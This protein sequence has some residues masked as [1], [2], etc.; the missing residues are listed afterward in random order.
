MENSI[1][2]MENYILIME[3]QKIVFIEKIP[4]KNDPDVNFGWNT[5]I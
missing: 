2:L 5:T 1:L 3:K 4:I